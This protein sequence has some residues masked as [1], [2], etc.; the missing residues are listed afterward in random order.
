MKSFLLLNVYLCS[1]LF[2]LSIL[3][4]FRFL[5]RNNC[6]IEEMDEKIYFVEYRLHSHCTWEMEDF[7]S[8]SS[9]CL[10]SSYSTQLSKKK[11]RTNKEKLP[12]LV[13][14]EL[15]KRNP[16]KPYGCN[17]CD[18]QFIQRKSLIRH[19]RIHTGEKPYKCN[20]CNKQFSRQTHL[21]NH[22]RIH[23]GEKPYKCNE[24]NKQFSQQGSLKNHMRIHTGE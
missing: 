3:L 24:C 8:L 11:E 12:G 4:F 10:I 18:K 2:D 21:T 9:P 6:I 15:Y 7:L 17:D 20:E 22:K 14:Q 23:T 1:K 19:K 13:C 16:S 5:K